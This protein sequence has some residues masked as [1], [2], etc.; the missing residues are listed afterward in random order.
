MRR[1]TQAHRTYTDACAELAK[2]PPSSACRQLH[3]YGQYDSLFPALSVAHPEMF[4]SHVFTRGAWLWAHSSYSTRCFPAG[5]FGETISEDLEDGVMIPLLDMLNHDHAACNTGWPTGVQEVD[6]SSSSAA[7][8]GVGR[9]LVHEAIKKGKDI[10]FSYGM[11]SNLALVHYGFTMWDNPHEVVNLATLIPSALLAAIAAIAP[12]EATGDR[13]W[14][15][16][17]QLRALR[18]AF[19][20]PEALEECG[21]VSVTNP[22]PS[23]LLALARAACMS[24][25]E[26]HNAFSFSCA[27][28]PDGHAD[29]NMPVLRRYLAS[30]AESVGESIGEETE[31]AALDMVESL[32]EEAFDAATKLLDFSDLC[33]DGADGPEVLEE[34]CTAV[35]AVD[36]IRCGDGEYAITPRGCQLACVSSHLLVLMAAMD[37]VRQMAGDACDDGSENE[38][39]SSDDD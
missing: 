36:C 27:C 33:L 7:L 13:A 1:C 32:I 4:P 28:G 17:S 10:I 3:L 29:A 11:K 39:D 5:V 26:F 23:H 9:M 12:D 6:G 20:T 37:A 31:L 16:S 15:S 8:K 22:L 24:E 18:A 2:S 19:E 38:E 25:D 30:N 21:G 35:K 14:R 34:A